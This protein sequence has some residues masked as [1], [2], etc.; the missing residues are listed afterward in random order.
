MLEKRHNVE[1]D[2]H[3]K[4]GSSLCPETRI[5]SLEALMALQKTLENGIPPQLADSSPHHAEDDRVSFRRAQLPPQRLDSALQRTSYA[6]SRVLRR[7]FTGMKKSEQM[8]ANGRSAQ[9]T[10]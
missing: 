2:L 10:A 8:S 7:L 4:E 9:K 5:Y 1:R 6:L 3:N